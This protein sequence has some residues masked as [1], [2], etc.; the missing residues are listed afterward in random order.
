MAYN[1][2]ISHSWTYSDAYEKFISLLDSYSYFIYNNH[3]VPKDDPV[4][5]NGS[6]K[7]LYDAIYN[8]MYN[9]HAVII[10][11]G[12]YS[13]YSKWIIKEIQIAKNEFLNPKPIIGVKPW[14]QTNISTVVQDNADIIVG[15]NSNSIVD[16]IRKFSR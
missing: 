2:F 8:K 16:A 11:G 15:W 10:M 1:L 6:D 7:Q 4:H 12:V 13:T 9:C 14:A 5:T 3:S